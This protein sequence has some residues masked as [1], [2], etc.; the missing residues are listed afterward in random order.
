MQNEAGI[1]KQNDGL[2]RFID[3]QQHDF[4]IA[5]HELKAGRK[6][7][8]WMWYIFPQISGLGFSSTSIYYALKDLAEASAYLK[9]PLLGTRLL[10]ITKVLLELPGND[11]RLIFGRPDDLKLKSCMTLF[12]LLSGTQS[13]FQQVLNKFFN[14]EMDDKTLALLNQDNL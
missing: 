5:L 12:A 7:S 11:A 10:E 1:N 2:G 8:H 3:A 4:K 9:H 6:R 14:G 13:V